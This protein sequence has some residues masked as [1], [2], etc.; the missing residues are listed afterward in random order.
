MSLPPVISGFPDLPVSV[1]VVFRGLLTLCFQG[2]KSCEVGVLKEFFAGQE[3]DLVFRK[4]I[5]SPDCPSGPDLSYPRPSSSFELRVNNPHPSADGVFIIGGATFDRTGAGNHPNDFRWMIDFESDLYDTPVPKIPDKVTPRLTINKGVFYAHHTTLTGFNAHPSGGSGA[6]KLGG[7]SIAEVMAARIY[8]DAG[9][10]VDVVI[11][12]STVDTLRQ[13][14]GL[15]YQIDVFNLCDPSSHAACRYL[16]AHP[17]DKRMRNDFYMYYNAINLTGGLEEYQLM[18]V[19][20][21]QDSDITGICRIE[22]EHGT[23]PAPCG[24]SGFG[25]SGSFG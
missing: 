23:D 6:V 20:P 4:W 5:K 25:Q 16:P 13:A 17:S 18:A 12:G 19:F 3:H 10:S 14:T 15:E 21:T 24:P 8:L 22:K 7:G 2:A 9:G 1:T 11:D